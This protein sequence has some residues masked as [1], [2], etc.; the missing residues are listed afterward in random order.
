MASLG[1]LQLQ[2]SLNCL[3]ES[4][5]V[6]APTLKLVSN[7]ACEIVA[8]EVSEV[9]LFRNNR[10]GNVIDALVFLCPALCLRDCKLELL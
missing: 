4:Q 10:V 5:C 8:I 1:V 2:S 3:D 9:I 7:D 6:A